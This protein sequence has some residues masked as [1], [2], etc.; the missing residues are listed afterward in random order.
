[1]SIETTLD[2]LAPY[3]RDWRGCFGLCETPEVLLYLTGW[4][5][6]RLRAAR[7]R[8]WKTPRRKAA[9]LEGGCFRGWPATP[10]AAGAALGISPGPR[11]C[12]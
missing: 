5:R 10:P 9:L 12:P 6:L 4:V 1:V 8:H 7:W 2:E 3:M 11:L